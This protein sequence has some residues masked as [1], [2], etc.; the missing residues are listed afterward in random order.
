MIHDNRGYCTPTQ[1]VSHHWHRGDY[2]S[3]SLS[4]AA[5]MA[6]VAHHIRSDYNPEDRERLEKETGQIPIDEAEEWN[7]A[8]T[9]SAARRAPPPSFVPARIQYD[10]WGS[11][12]SL[13]HAISSNTPPPDSGTSKWYRALTRDNS[14]S[15]NVNLPPARPS[16]A[17]SEAPKPKTEATTKNNW[18]I[19]RALQSEPSTKPSSPA[20]S[21]ADLLARDPPPLPSEGR[22]VPPVWLAIGP[23]NKGF[24][25]LQKSGWNEGEGLGAHVARPPR[26]RSPAHKSNG[27]ESISY[28]PL[29]GASVPAGDQKPRDI[30]PDLID[31]TQS[32][33]ESE[34]DFESFHQ[35]PSLPL[36]PVSSAYKGTDPHSQKS[37]LTPIPTI[38]KS[39][40]LGI[41]LKAKTE[42][43]YKQSKKRV[44]HN[45]AALASHIRA[46]EELRRK[47]AEV[48]RG[49]R[50][51]AK[52][53]RREEN[54]RKHMLA[55]LNE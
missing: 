22:F 6:T 8:P 3:S 12:V 43:P 50:G 30:Q 25:L 23:S 29:R 31:L 51:F 26:P 35:S 38:L 2:V 47:K 41:G 33:S 44:T 15:G 1:S 11:A 49:R 54:E 48:G 32:D 7:T 18:F 55:Y 42:G 34:D 21:L 4:S 46:A 13:T 52:V 40:R 17:P 24:N 14:V 10:E 9:F 27:A 37:L 20:P 19:K 45:Q 16:S 39:D 5:I 36:V 28:A 53:R